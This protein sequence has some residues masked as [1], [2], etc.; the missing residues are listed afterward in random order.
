MEMP[1]ILTEGRICSLFRR[2]HGPKP[3]FETPGIG[4][5]VVVAMTCSSFAAIG[6]DTNY[7]AKDSLIPLPACLSS[8][9]IQL[10]YNACTA[11]QLD[12][13]RKDVRHWRDEERIRAGY[14]DTQYRRP[15]LQ[16]S[17]SSFMQPQM[18]AEDRY[19]YD[20]ETGKYTVDRYLDDLNRRFGGIDSVLIWQSYP[21]IGIDSRSQYDLIR[22]LPGGIQALRAMVQDF[23]KSGVH[24]L[25]PVMV[26]DQ[27]THREGNS[28]WDS[29][30]KIMAEIGADGVNGDTLTGV[31]KAFRDASDQTGHPLV[32]E[33]EGYVGHDEMLAY[34]NMSWGYWR[35]PFAP[36]LSQGKLLEPRHMINI[37][38]R[39]NRSKTDDLQFA[40]FNG[41][42]LE[43]WENVWSI[44]NGM[45]PRGAETIRRVASI[46][47][48]FAPFLISQDWEPLTPTVQFGVFATRWPMANEE[49]FTI[50]NRNE[51]NLTG[52]Q[53]QL[54]YKE[55]L[56]YYDLWHGRELI[57]VRH[58]ESIWL[59]FDIDGRGF[60]A[61]FVTSELKN[62]A[63]KS[64]LQ[65][66][67]DWDAAPL[68]SF[69]DEWKPLQQKILPIE[70]VAHP[71]SDPKDMV[72]IP[73][74]NFLFRVDGVEIEGENWAGL[75]VQYPWED[76]PRRHHV[77]EVK[78]ASFW[79]DRHPVTNSEFKKFIDH[80][81]YHPKDD[82]NFLHD[83]KDGRFPSGWD[84]K[85]VT[86]VSLED[87][88]AYAAW[89]GKRLP[90]EWEWQ[91]AAQGDDGRI[92]PWGNLWDVEAVPTPNRTRDLTSPDDIDSHPKGAS[93]FGVM[94]L[95]GNVWQ[96]T[97]EFQDEHTRTAVIRGGS[98]YQPQGSM[99][100]FPKA[101]KNTEHGKYLLM[102]PSK[103]RAGTLGFR[104]VID[105]E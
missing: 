54:P 61:V 96:W 50:I 85:P 12:E 45:T 49:L 72:K 98:Y 65:M 31:P 53:L 22:A 37:S 89:E 68:N 52:P 74:A 20:R 86:W 77:H 51:Y 2:N 79:I 46:E 97:D 83:W 103:D 44:W 21:N 102:A 59:N 76:S 73:A 5:L 18:M 30:A 92:Y 64:V 58:E 80:S 104:C 88:R 67:K 15:E 90:H 33:P 25:F 105:A 9:E 91:Y 62:P 13:W 94:D 32:F 26:W 43:T 41:V 93:P 28:D 29:T 82:Y 42:G 39:W 87:A 95:V 75:D 47:R 71:A 100:Y 60:G 84:N 36:L 17:Q 38:D 78:I 3:F 6:Q 70:K 99:W 34:N 69:S 19:F 14:T 16:W 55:G 8:R 35:Y 81:H 4:C 24:V 23:H 56:H 1:R 48:A 11:S 63:E 101:F 10:D 66:G 57:P 7:P 27:G 40:F